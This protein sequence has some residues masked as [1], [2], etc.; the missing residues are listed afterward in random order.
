MST[1][2]ITVGLQIHS[3]HVPKFYLSLYNKSPMQTILHQFICRKGL[4]WSHIACSE[5]SGNGSMQ[6]CSMSIA[7]AM[8]ILQFYAKP[9]ICMCKST[10]GRGEEVLGEN[11]G[12]LSH[13]SIA[14]PCITNV[15]ATRR[16]NFSQWECSFLW[17]L[18]ESCDAIGW[19]SCD[20][21]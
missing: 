18:R 4:E 5:P 7:N 9:W 6:D 13:T 3:K 11:W 20:V 8:E 17:K 19:N 16:N 2:I 21:S 14:G 12:I 1:K 10:G 15:I